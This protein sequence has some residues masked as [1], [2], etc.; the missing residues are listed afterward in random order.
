[1]LHQGMGPI[2]ENQVWGFICAGVDVNEWMNMLSNMKVF[3]CLYIADTPPQ[4]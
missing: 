4:E 2:P 1:M 3:V